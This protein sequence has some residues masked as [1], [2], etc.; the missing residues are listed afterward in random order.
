MFE[1]KEKQEIAK[2]ASEHGH[3]ATVRKFNSSRLLLEVISAFG[4]EDTRNI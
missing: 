2:L 3:A 4:A 1:E